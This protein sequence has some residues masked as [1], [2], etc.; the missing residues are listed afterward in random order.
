[1]IAPQRRAIGYRLDGSY[2]EDGDSSQLRTVDEALL[3]NPPHVGFESGPWRRVDWL[4]TAGLAAL[5][6]AWIWYRFQPN[7]TPIED[8]AMLLRYA[9]NFAGGHGIRW[10]LDQA[11]V[12]G[13]TDFL[14]MVAT[15]ALSR[16]AHIG[17]L[18]A[19]RV[20]N[21]SAYVATVLLVFAGSRKLLGS[22]RWLSAGLAAYLV[23]CP[24]IQMANGGF[25]AP[26]FAAMVL[27]CWCAGLWY[28]LRSPSWAAGGAMAILGLL[29]GLTRPEGV[30]IAGFLLIAAVYLQHGKAGA[31]DGLP[32][33]M[34]VVVSYALV[35][36][37]LGGAYFLWRWRYFGYPLP[38]PFYIKGNGHLYM[39]SGKYAV[40]NLFKLLTPVLPLLPL[41]WVSVRTRRLTKALL[42]VLMCF[43]LMWLLLTNSNNHFMR[44]QYAILPVALMTLPA[45]ANDMEIGFAIAPL[46]G[47]PGTQRVAV[48]IAAVLAV[49]ASML[50]ID[51]LFP[52]SDRAFGMRAF[53]QRLQPF[54]GKRY[55][56]V[57]TEAG[58][59]PL[60]SEWRAIDGLGL[61]DSY[62]AHHGQK[63]SMDYLAR[64]NPE[65]IMVHVFPEG[66]GKQFDGWLN[67]DPPVQGSAL[68]NFEIMNFYAKSHG[69]TLAA[70]WGSNVCNLHFYWVRPGFADHDAIVQR[71]REHP[72]FF[73]DD[74]AFSYDYRDHLDS[75]EGCMRG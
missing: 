63:L 62:I 50:Y 48:S 74:G 34:P 53:A 75:V 57:V 33:W 28:A 61:N 7:A 10:N 8:A 68:W 17:V 67:G 30:L 32:G 69:Y 3:A 56:M 40:L 18:A 27:A 39:D 11:P 36:G 64:N 47:W 42:L 70:A 5:C 71:I 15:G 26:C 38:N 1:M 16:V 41:G 23:A 37:I 4:L 65:L 49:A 43:T 24:A 72:Y 14:Y 73:L 35:F 51:R 54:A 66:A 9:Q 6:L 13:A 55:T 19:S 59:L 29:A 22:N 31:R 12:D 2:N 44:F 58:T 45:L 21:L 52:F 25:G 46:A 20:L 60:Y